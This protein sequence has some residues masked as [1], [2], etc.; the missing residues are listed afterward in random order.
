MNFGD[1]QAS[2]DIVNFPP[3]G[4]VVGDTDAQTLTNKRIVARIASSLNPSSI[5]PNSDTTDLVVVSGLAQALSIGN[6]TGNPTDGQQLR[7]RFLD[8]GSAQTLAFAGG[9]QGGSLGLP[10]ASIGSASLSLMLTFQFDNSLTKWR[11]TG[12]AN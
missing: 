9:Y 8:T 1:I 2:I 3:S 10:A 4:A 6:P 7:I 12:K 11:L 5:T